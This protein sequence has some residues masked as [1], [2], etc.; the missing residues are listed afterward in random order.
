MKIGVSDSANQ[1]RAILL[2]WQSGDLPRFRWEVDAV[3]AL[4]PPASNTL[5]TERIDLLNGV[6]GELR[7]IEHTLADSST[8]FCCDL[9]RHLAGRSVDRGTESGEFEPGG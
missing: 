7:A 1:A 8:H 4:V 3:A 6:A 9:L 2:A 5:E